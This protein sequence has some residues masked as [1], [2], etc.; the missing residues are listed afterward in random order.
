MIIKWRADKVFTVLSCR[1]VENARVAF[2]GGT[3]NLVAHN[4]QE[5]GV[6][7]VCQAGDRNRWIRPIARL[8]VVQMMGY[9]AANESPAG[10]GEPRPEPIRLSLA[11]LSK[12][13][14]RIGVFRAMAES[15]LRGHGPQVWY[16]RLRSPRDAP[17]SGKYPSN[18]ASDHKWVDCSWIMRAGPNDS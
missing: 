6:Q 11:A 13:T 4:F 8:V 17:R 2:L 16:T 3:N 18:L 12:C 5:I 1:S 7:P 14:R 15:L 9:G 10:P